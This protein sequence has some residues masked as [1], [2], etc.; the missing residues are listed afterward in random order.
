MQ[1][2]SALSGTVKWSGGRSVEGLV[3]L[4]QGIAWSPPQGGTYRSGT[5]L[6][7]YAATIDGRGRYDITEIDP[8]QSYGAIVAR[9][10]HTP[11]TPKND[12]PSFAP[13][14]AAVWDCVVHHGITIRGRV[15]GENTGRLLKDVRVRCLKD[16]ESIQDGEQEVKSDGCFEF[17]LVTG[18]GSYLVHPLPKLSSGDPRARLAALYGKEVQLSAGEEIELDLSFFEPFTIQVRAVDIEGN[19]IEGTRTELVQRAGIGSFRGRWQGEKPTDENG[20]FSW[21][22]FRPE[23]EAW[24]VLSKNGYVESES[25]HYIG[26][27]GEVFPEETIVLHRSSGVTGIALDENETPI[28]DALI[29]WVL[30]CDGDSTKVMPTLKTDS[31]GAFARAYHVPAT[32]VIF[33]MTVD[34]GARKYR[35]VSEPVECVA[36]HIMDF[37]EIVFAPLN[38]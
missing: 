14:Q 20:R 21:S 28:P 26:Q 7:E 5:L 10:D 2:R 18:P 30:H 37:G 32:E 13:G 3:V 8:G 31:E 9:E 23:L 25:S 16:G 17:N 19:P 24:I 6:T 22:G 34:D 4:L 11:L 36:D 27:P 29:E 35:W 38:D 33:E 12:L 15:L 1:E